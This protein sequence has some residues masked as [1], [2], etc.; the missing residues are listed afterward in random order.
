MD[1][2]FD[3]SSADGVEGPQQVEGRGRREA[4]DGLPFVEDYECLWRKEGDGLALLHTPETPTD[5]V[6]PL[7]V[8]PL[9]VLWISKGLG[10]CQGTDALLW[11]RSSHSSLGLWITKMGSDEALGR[12][13]KKRRSML[14]SFSWDLG[15]MP[16][17]PMG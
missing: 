10:L 8:R 13:G 9:C 6:L 17:L 12:G 16:S 11:R 15:L 1:K 3:G 5:Q 2:H 4:E 14:W 7:E